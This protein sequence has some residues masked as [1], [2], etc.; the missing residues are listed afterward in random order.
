MLSIVEKVIFRKTIA[1]L[2]DGGRG[3]SLL[4]A[5]T[6]TRSTA[7]ATLVQQIAGGRN[8]RRHHRGRQRAH[9]LR[10]SG[11]QQLV[12]VTVVGMRVVMLV[13]VVVVHNRGRGRRR[14][15]IG[16]RIQ[17]VQLLARED[18]LVVLPFPASH[19]FF[20]NAL[21]S[22]RGGGKKKQWKFC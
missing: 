6:T 22:L 13:V 4:G 8:G 11:L 16:A 12:V 5:T 15:R 7:A 19:Q 14:G 17:Q 21:Q 20:S 10:T 18:I 9:D 1:Q 2:T 3:H